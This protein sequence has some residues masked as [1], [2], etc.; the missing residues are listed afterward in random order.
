[1]AN[2]VAT[3]LVYI[4]VD[5]AYHGLTVVPSVTLTSIMACRVYRGTKLGIPRGSGDLS[6]PTLNPSG[7][8]AI[9]LSALRF[10]ADRSGMRPAERS[11]DDGSDTT[12][13]RRWPKANE[14]HFST[15]AHHETGAVP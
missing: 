1:M 13:D 7:N 15:E 12:G 8:I 9:P 5:P 2:I 10:S 14:S 11:A 4:P 6:L 3:L